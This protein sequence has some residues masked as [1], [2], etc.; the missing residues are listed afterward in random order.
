V[1][2]QIRAAPTRDRQLRRRQISALQAVVVLQVLVGIS[3]LTA[4]FLVRAV[5]IGPGLVGVV[6]AGGVFGAILAKTLTHRFGASYTALGAISLCLPFAL[7]IPFTSRG[8][9]LLFFIAGLSIVDEL[10]SVRTAVLAFAIGTTIS[11]CSISARRCARH[12][13]FPTLASSAHSA[14]T[15]PPAEVPRPR[16]QAGSGSNFRKAGVPCGRAV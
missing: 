8:A 10:L 6:F 1:K 7:L 13:N 15:A 11:G 3:S 16:S 4:L 14:L 12:A 5:G 9:G 2:D